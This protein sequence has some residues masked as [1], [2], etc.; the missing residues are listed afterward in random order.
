MKNLKIFVLLAVVMFLAACSGGSSSNGTGASGVTLT[1]PTPVP[2]PPQ[3]VLTGVA[4]VGAALDGA[5]IEVIDAAG[6]LVD[7]GDSATGTDGSYSVVLPANIALPVVIRATPPGGTP[8]LSIVQ[9]PADGSTDV[10]A[11]INP[12]TNL[13]SS[14]VRGRSGDG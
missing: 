8:L 5:L 2:A 7:I 1:Q 3:L 11:N 9:A 10:V 13:V 6:N 14:S 4:A 12:V